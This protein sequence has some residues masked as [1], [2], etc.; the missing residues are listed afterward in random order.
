MTMNVI[1]LRQTISSYWG[2]VAQVMVGSI[3][4]AGMAQLAISLPFTPVPMS[5]Q[6]LGVAL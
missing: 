6:T 5:L 4:L 3:F 1:T 2:S